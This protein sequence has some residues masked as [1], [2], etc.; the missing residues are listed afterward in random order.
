[1]SGFEITDADG[2]PIDPDSFPGRQVLRGQRPDP[3]LLRL[4]DRSTGRMQWTLVKA[5]EFTDADGRRLAVNLLEDVTEAKE[6]EL[7]ERFLASASKVLASSL[8]Y[9][10]TLEQVAHLAVPDLA[11]WCSVEMLDGRE[12][13][14][15][16]LAHVDPSKIEFARAFRERYPPRIDDP[17]GV[18]AVLSSG[19]SEL[20]TTIDEDLVISRAADEEHARLLREVQMRSAIVVPM[21]SR[22]ESVIGAIS[23]VAAE[24]AGRYDEDDLAFLEEFARR[25]AT[26]VENARLYRERSETAEVLQRSLVPA[27]LP[28]VPGWQSAMRYHPASV[29]SEV[30]GD[31]LDLIATGGG[32]TVVVGDVTGKG[33]AAAALTGLTRYS[34]RTASMLGLGPAETLGLL[35]RLL[36]EQPG[37]SPVTAVVAQV[38]EANEE[39]ILTLAS[40]G[41]PLPVLLRAGHP[42]VEV[43]TRGTVLGFQSCSTWHDDA[44][45]LNAGDALLFYTDGIIDTIGSNDRFGEA[46]FQALLSEAPSDPEELLAAIENALRGFRVGDA[47]DDIAMLALRLLPEHARQRRQARSLV[48][49]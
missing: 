44:L 13:R 4:V 12:I 9:E 26:A 42:P 39:T 49:E 25:A 31:F 18:G 29:A 40:A 8:D 16:A 1:L 32:L 14:Q 48:G 33:P 37:L 45:R 36:L 6:Q 35:N 24:S 47:P 34:A 22:D 5:T 3:L 23:F 10:Q 19:K 41:H 20:Y 2:R 43:G 46:R 11:D 27:A 28:P 17:A 38:A 7:H 21:R 15:V 30:G